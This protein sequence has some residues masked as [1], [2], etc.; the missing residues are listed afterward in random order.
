[1]H[2]FWISSMFRKSKPLRSVLVNGREELA[3]QNAVS[4]W[5]RSWSN[6][7]RKCTAI[8]SF[9]KSFPALLPDQLPHKSPFSNRSDRRSESPTRGKSKVSFSIMI[10]WWK[11]KLSSLI[12]T[13]ATGTQRINSITLVETRAEISVFGAK[14]TQ[15]NFLK[16]LEYQDKNWNF[17]RLKKS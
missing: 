14:K 8:W 4:S 5:I 3:V 17:G 7:G 13:R 9:R 2:N 15:K 10:K 12:L 6:T 16:L 1:M 11:I